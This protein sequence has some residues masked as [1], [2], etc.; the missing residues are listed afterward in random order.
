MIKDKFK[1]IITKLETI[2]KVE[3]LDIGGSEDTIKKEIENTKI[4]DIK[5]CDIKFDLIKDLEKEGKIPIRTGKYNLVVI[6][7]ILEHTIEPEKI[8]KEAMRISRDHIIIG[9]PNDL[10]IDNRIRYLLGRS[11]GFDKT[12]HKQITNYKQINE[13]V[14]KNIKGWEIL[15]TENFFAVKGGRIIPIF[16][17]NYLANKIPSLFCKEKMWLIKRIR[18]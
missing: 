6:S 1:N 12:G 16:I 17:R 2:E 18:K 9:L 15:E 5:D 3:C 13:F 10:T 4:M 7:Q 8:L 11:G 14:E